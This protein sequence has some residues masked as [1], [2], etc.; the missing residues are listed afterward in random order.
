MG[1]PVAFVGPVAQPAPV[2]IMPRSLTATVSTAALAHNLAVARGHAA[3]A[4]VWAVVKADA[5][6]HGLDVA[7]IGFADADGLAL[8][9][10]DGAE[11]LRA[12]G[13]SRPILMLEGAFDR[14]DYR[15]ARALDLTVTIHSVAQ[16]DWLEA[17]V[18]RSPPQPGA[19]GLDLM[20][21]IDTGMSRL[22]LAPRQVA[23]QAARLRALPGVARLGWMTHFANADV[24]GGAAAALASFAAATGSA[25]AS[26]PTARSDERRSLSNSAAL[27]DCPEARG[28]WVRPGIMLYGATPFADRDA[29]ALGLMPAMRLEGS[30]IAIREL[31]RGDAYGYGS[32][33]V[34][35]RPLRIGIVDCGY[36]DGYPRHA[37]TGTPV[38]VAGTATRTIGRVSMDMLAVD[39]TPVGSAVV[40]SAVE[41]WG[42]QI[43]VDAVAHAAGTIGYELLCA[44]APRVRRAVSDRGVGYRGARDGDTDGRRGSGAGGD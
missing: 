3:G 5:Y 1:S 40:G 6:G 35:D 23:A 30:L 31:A 43:P 37:P 19:R 33:F 28:D 9:E 13:W 29:R 16:V 20:I 24:R 41:L 34:A 36:A 7:R 22:G 38:A 39:L 42:E 10:W 17:H 8:L 21:K 18:R 32:T 14:D 25:T 4:R 12:R 27:I 26:S 44:V 15:V 2:Y 11:R